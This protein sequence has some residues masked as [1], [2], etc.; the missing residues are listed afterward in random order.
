MTTASTDDGDPWITC[1]DAATGEVL[2][3]VTRMRPDAVRAAVSEAATAAEAWTRTSGRRR[4]RV[5]E[6]LLDEVVGAADELCRLSAH[7]SGKTMLQ[8]LVGEVLP[9]CAAIAAATR[10]T[11]RLRPSGRVVGVIGSDRFPLQGVV[12]PIASV[13]GEGHA[14]VVKLSE[15]A[16]WSG[17]LYTEIVRNV[18]RQHG[19]D[20]R[21]V[22]TVTGDVTAAR[23]L[24]ETELETVM[25]S[26][27]LDVLEQVERAARPGL[28]IQWQAQGN[29]AM[30]VC[31]HADLQRAVCMAMLAAFTP[32]PAPLVAAERIVVHARCYEPFVRAARRAIETLRVGDPLD[33]TADCGR[34]APSVGA[35]HVHALVADARRHGARL[36]VGGERAHGRG[37]LEPT[38]VVDVPPHAR[39]AREPTFGPVM[40]VMRAEHDDE[41]IALVDG[42]PCGAG[43]SVLCRDRRHAAALSLRTRAHRCLIDGIG[44]ERLVLRLHRP[45]SR[46]VLPAVAP[47]PAGPHTFAV[48]EGLLR[49]RFSSG[50]RERLRAAAELIRA[51]RTLHTR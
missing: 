15:H 9:T 20:A 24:L 16:S 43:V 8:A 31:E 25:G 19:L 11:R 6:S 38:L 44:F 51:G 39:I 41:A 40:V 47:Y 27:P 28:E 1:R 48:V 37:E 17:T 33:E 42:A 14:V 45:S 49:L 36:L 50:V 12:A 46:V 23:A 32:L 10:A 21:L 29:E 30:I 13:L 22:Q 18:L 3:Q 26:G 7:E 34:V 2:G 4:A 35:D 5:L